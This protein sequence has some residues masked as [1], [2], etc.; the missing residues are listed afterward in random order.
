[1]SAAVS[2]SSS[3]I[4]VDNVTN[5]DKDKHKRSVEDDEDV[6]TK[7]A[8]TSKNVPNLRNS[9][10]SHDTDITNSMDI[11]LLIQPLEKINSN[12]RAELLLK[13]WEPDHTFIFPISRDRKLKFQLSWLK[14]WSWLTYSKLHDGAFCKFCVLFKRNEG[15][16]GNQ[17]LGKLVLEKFF[18]WKKEI[19]EFNKHEATKYH[20]NSILDADNLL[21]I[22]NKSKEFIDIQLNNKLKIEIQENRKKIIPIIE[23][24]IFCGRQGLALRGH[25]D[26][27]II[28]LQNSQIYN[29]GNFRESLR[30]KVEA[31]DKNLANHL[32][33]APRNATYLSPEIQN[34]VI[35]ACSNMIIEQLVSKINSA[36]CFTVL[37]DETTD[38]SG[39]E[40]LD[41]LKFV[42]VH[43]VTGKG[44][45]TTVMDS[46][47]ELGLE[48]KYLRGQG[49]DGAA[50]MSGHFN[51]VQAH[52][53]KNYPLAHYIHCSFH[54]LN[55]AISDAFCVF[56][57]YPKR[58]NVLTESIS[59]IC[60]SSNVIRL[61]LLCPTRWVDRHDSIIVFIDLFDA[62]IES[63]TKV[64]SWFDKDSSS[65]AYQLLCSIKQPE[66]VLAT[67]VLAKVFGISLPLSKHLQT[68][69]ID[70]IDAI[71]NADSVRCIIES[72]RKNAES[73]FKSIFD[74][75]KTKCDALNI[76]ISLPRRTNVQKNHCNRF[77]SHKTVLKNFTCL[78][79][80][81]NGK[82]EEDN[83]KQLIEMYQ[84]DL[85]CGKLAAI[86]EIKTWQQK[87]VQSQVFP[88][89]SLDALQKCNEMI[90]PST[91][92]LLQI[93]A[94]LSVTTANNERSF[95]TLKRLKTY[96]RNTTCENRL[97]GLALLNIYREIILKPEDVL[98]KLA[99]KTRRI[100]L[101]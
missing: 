50:A 98:N 28:S 32:E 87:F 55:L 67:F 41:F 99:I 73:E 23:T 69:N 39:I 20:R 95:S 26:S 78:L 11:G 82:F 14:K 72:I 27:G 85:D 34:E 47:N 2:Q 89:N 71:E 63:L 65:G 17:K 42:P 29:D 10:N 52:V 33:T 100:R 43:D 79:P 94:N 4:D 92:K 59:S 37:A 96:L 101:M 66:F 48:L 44:L 36:K 38:I 90:F 93:L 74:E 68:K 18:N 57:K 62:I 9:E 70:L 61:K 1:M 3:K 25:N 83:I 16:R 56:F 22:Y 86:G 24:I 84:D 77:L 75:V 76:E 15:G 54:S 60:P 64:C 5:T 40:Q 30:F 13:I 8:K 88:K 81:S 31:G 46:L 91:F 6:T 21:S 49:Y 97:N 58:N 35:N 51:G 45:A 7:I 80:S 12:K 19:E 53:T